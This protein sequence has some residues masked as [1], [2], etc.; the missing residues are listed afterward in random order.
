MSSL[1]KNGKRDID[2]YFVKLNEYKKK[3]GEKVILLWQAGTFFE[4]Y[5]K[6]FMNI[7]VIIT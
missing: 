2:T 3:Y 4:V 6:R 5:A 1:S 7:L